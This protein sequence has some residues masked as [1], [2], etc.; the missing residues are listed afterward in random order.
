MKRTVI[1]IF[2]VLASIAVSGFIVGRSGNGSGVN[3][4]GYPTNDPSLSFSRRESGSNTKNDLESSKVPAEDGNLTNALV[5]SYINSIIASNPDGPAV[6][7]GERRIRIPDPNFADQINNVFKTKPFERKDLIILSG[8]SAKEQKDYFDKLASI[9][10]KNLSHFQKT[11]ID[12]IDEWLNKQTGAGVRQY[13]AAA[14]AQIDDLL[15]TKVPSNL[16]EFH[17][18]L[19]NLWQKKL[20]VFRALADSNKDPLKAVLA[21]GE[22]A[23][24]IQ[25]SRGMGEV[26]NRKVANLQ[27]EQ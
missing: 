22:V 14:A 18:E 9:S 7:N 5:S 23:N 16:A 24:L 19:L 6:V 15:K 10:E 12:L 17:L 20:L 11:E 4:T 27:Y 25:E 13:A 2:I 8:T 21:F 26:A 3:I 1:S